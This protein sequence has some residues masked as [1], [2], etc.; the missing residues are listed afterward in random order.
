M[1]TTNLSEALEDAIF[2][3]ADIEN[4]QEVLDARREAILTSVAEVRGDSRR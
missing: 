4:A 2:E 3:L 1:T